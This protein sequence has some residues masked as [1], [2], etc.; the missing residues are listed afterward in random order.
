MVV[1][2]LAKFFCDVNVVKLA[3]WLRFAGF[4]TMVVREL[5]QS[6][7]ESLCIKERRVFLTRKKKMKKF[8]GSHEI[9]VSDNVF[10]QLSYILSKYKLD[11]SLIGSY[12]I[13]CNVKLREY[14]T[15]KKYCPRCGKIYWKG[16]H[17]DNMIKMIRLASQHL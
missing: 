16:S 7:I 17:Y 13:E 15:E 14:E 9:L 5:S 1:D 8:L 12:C 4:N 10:E 3:K 2:R 6:K 11:D